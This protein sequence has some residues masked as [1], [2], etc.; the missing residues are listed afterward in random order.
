MILLVA[1]EVWKAI[2]IDGYQLGASPT[3]AVVHASHT[4]LSGKAR[5]RNAGTRLRAALW[6]VRQWML[7]LAFAQLYGQSVS[8]C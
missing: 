7:G 1:H 2:R 5:T 3:H 8:G 6:P 4:R